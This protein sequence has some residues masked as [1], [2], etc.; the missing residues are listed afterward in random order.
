HRVS[1]QGASVEQRRECRHQRV[2]H[3]A[4]SWRLAGVAGEYQLD[5][6]TG[7]RHSRRDR[8]SDHGRAEPEAGDEPPEH[9]ST[10]T[11]PYGL[12]GLYRIRRLALAVRNRVRS[13]AMEEPLLLQQRDD[14]GVVVTLT[15]N[16]PQAFNALSEAMLAALG[17]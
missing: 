16:R 7:V 12:D 17:E 5:V 11:D 8:G 6:R 14:R 15:L 3:S 1:A 2:I 4:H 9:E 13:H 10:L